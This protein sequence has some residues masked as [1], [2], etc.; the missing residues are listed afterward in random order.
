MGW[1]AYVIDEWIS[2]DHI[3]LHKNP[4]YFRSDENL[5]YFDNL[6]F[7]FLGSSDEALDGSLAGECDLIDQTAMLE[8]QTAR[9]AEL[10]KTGQVQTSYQNDAG[11]EQITFG[12]TPA[13]S[14]RLEFFAPKEVRQAAAMCIDRE[15]L[16]S[17]Q[18]QGTQLLVDSYTASVNPLYNPEV[19]HYSYDL[20]KASDLLASVGWQDTD[21][22]P[23]TPRIAQGVT[24]IPDGTPFV[25][26]YLVSSDSKSQSG[27]LAIQ[28][29][30]QQCG[31]GVKIK[32][33]QPGEYLAPGPDGPVFGRS[34]DMAQFAWAASVEP[35][36]YLYLTSQI[37][38]PYPEFAKG[39]G[40]VNASGYSN[41]EYD[42]ACENALFSLPDTSQ[43]TQAHFQAQEIFSTELPGLPLYLHSTVSVYR[44]DLCNY[45]SVS[46]LDS[47]LWNLENLDYGSGCPQ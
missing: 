34:F 24:G 14:Q 28:A 16:V 2:G 4:Q 27:A 3:S 22:D 19:L 17:D 36:C 30:L 39:W 25:V 47:P 33:L 35:A 45:T 40:G 44:P 20:Q 43:H 5:P 7:R 6:V 26:E 11:W 10:Q 31:L 41:P 38:G 42:Q 46:A 1:G 15:S 18:S 8:S 12:I 29:M 9:L 23:S 32:T 21:N 13:D 37:P